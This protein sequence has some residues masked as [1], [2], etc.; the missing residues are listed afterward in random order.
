MT[1]QLTELWVYLSASP[2]LGLTITLLAYQVAFW[3]YQRSG[4][5]PLANPVL[6]AVTMLVGLLLLTGTRYET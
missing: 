4:C 2:L 1:P 6:I 5:H 3:L